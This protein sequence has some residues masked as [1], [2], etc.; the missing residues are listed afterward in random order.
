MLH[1]IRKSMIKCAKNESYLDELETV[2]NNYLEFLREQ[3]PQQLEQFLTACRQVK[4]KDFLSL[5]DVVKQI[6]TYEK[7]HICQVIELFKLILVLP[8]TNASSET[9]FS[10]Y[11]GL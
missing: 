6:N 10:L 5:F 11:C 7:A 4:A 8:A 1:Y 2:F 3:L 9:F